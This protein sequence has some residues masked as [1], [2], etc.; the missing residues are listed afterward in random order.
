MSPGYIVYARSGN[1]LAMPFDRSRLEVTGE[2]VP[3]VEDVQHS[4]VTGGAQFSL[5][6]SGALAYVPGGP[7]QDRGTLVWVDRKGVAR[8]VGSHPAGRY[9]DVSLSPDGGR[10][11]VGSGVFESDVWV[12]DLTRAVLS[13]LTSDRGNV[14]P[15]WTPD[16]KRVIYWKTS[17]T[18]G[19]FWRAADG[20]GNEESVYKHERISTLGT[21]PG[22]WSGDGRVLVFTIGDPATTGTDLW[23]LSLDGDRK[24][25]PLI[26]TQFSER[27]PALSPDGR[28][29]AYTSNRSGRPEVYVQP[30]PDLTAMS[31]I[32]A[33]GGVEPKW[34]ANGREL[35]YRSG[36]RMMAVDVRTQP[37]FQP[38]PA[39]TLFE[40]SYNRSYDV[41]PDG[42]HFVMIRQDEAAT[43]L[44]EARVVLGWAEELKRRLGSR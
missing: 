2:A 18:G 1:L 26:Q 8:P 20:S 27:Q 42:Q 28:W 14:S 10:L 29:L 19:L 6:T 34:A 23:T 31:Q 16:G 24:S 4:S 9:F 44:A 7:A 39:R 25:K 38:Q 41:A 22:S 13:R 32:S 21:A 5:S 40:G 15:I 3:L 36:D 33:D 30:F 17:Q 37:N 35:F 12:Y 11:V 43:S